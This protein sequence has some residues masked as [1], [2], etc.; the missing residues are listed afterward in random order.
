MCTKQS[1]FAYRSWNVALP[2]FF[3]CE[4]K[5][6]FH[7][8]DAPLIILGQSIS[9]S[10][11][12]CGHHFCEIIKQKI[13]NTSD[14]F[15]FFFF[16]PL[17]GNSADNSWLSWH[18]EVGHF[19][20]PGYEGMRGTAAGENTFFPSFLWDGSAPSVTAAVSRPAAPVGSGIFGEKPQRGVSGNRRQWYARR[21]SG[22]GTG[23]LHM[24]ASQR[25]R[26]RW[27]LLEASCT[28]THDGAVWNQTWFFRAMP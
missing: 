17:R 6:H 20:R 9:L 11:S 21:A 16:C 15:F 7:Y 25:L 2:F 8:F 13:T 23:T 27:G 5:S 28:Q 10:L 26:G 24:G 14:F 3:F 1:S 4:K 19:W 22:G 12:L 18:L